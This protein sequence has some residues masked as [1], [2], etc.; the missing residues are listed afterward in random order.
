MVWWIKAKPSEA[1]ARG[2]LE[3]VR[4]RRITVV[5]VQNN[6][7]QVDRQDDPNK[8][9]TL[10]HLI[11]LFRCSHC[12]GKEMNG[13]IQ[14][15]TECI[16]FNEND[17]VDMC[18]Y[19]VQPTFFEAI[20]RIYF[21][22]LIIESAQST[23]PN[24][25]IKAINQLAYRSKQKLIVKWTDGR[26]DECN[27]GCAQAR[28]RVKD[29][30]HKALDA[31][32][33]S[34]ELI[35]LLKTMSLTSIKAIHIFS[36]WL[37]L[38]HYLLELKLKLFGIEMCEIIFDRLQLL[39]M[40][41]YE[42]QLQQFIIDLFNIWPTIQDDKLNKFV[43][44]HFV[45]FIQRIIDCKTDESNILIEQ[46]T[47][48]ICANTPVSNVRGHMCF[49]FLLKELL[50][51]YCEARL[52]KAIKKIDKGVILYFIDY[53]IEN[54]QNDTNDHCSILL[55]ILDHISTF[56]EIDLLRPL[57]TYTIK[58]PLNL[59]CFELIKHSLCPITTLVTYVQQATHEQVSEL[60]ECSE[61]D[62]A[63]QFIPTLLTIIEALAK[64]SQTEK[65]IFDSRLYLIIQK[66]LLIINVPSIIIRLIELLLDIGYSKYNKYNTD[67]ANFFLNQ[68]LA[69]FLSINFENP[70][71]LS[72][73]VLFLASFADIDPS[74]TIRCE[75]LFKAFFRQIEESTNN[76]SMDSC[77]FHLLS[78]SNEIVKERSRSKLVEL[79]S[80][81]TLD[82]I[83]ILGHTGELKRAA[84]ILLAE[85]L[86]LSPNERSVLDELIENQSNDDQSND[87]LIG[88]QRQQASF[89]STELTST[90]EIVRIGHDDFNHGH[91]LLT[92][93]KSAESHKIDHILRSYIPHLHFDQSSPIIDHKQQKDRLILTATARENV[94]K[95]LEVLDD[96]VPILLEGSTGVGKSA[97]VMEAAKLSGRELKR[98]NMSSRIS[99]DDLLGKVTIVPGEQGQ[100]V[101]FK[102]DNGPFT[103]AFIEGYWMLFDELNL[104]QDTVLQAIESA[105]DR[106]QLTIRNGSSAQQSVVV[107]HMH[108]NFR[109][110]A[111]QN[112]NTGFFKNKREK[113]SPSF[114]SRFRPLIF[115]ELPDIEWREIAHRKLLPYLFDEA[116]SLAELMVS[117]FNAKIKKMLNNEEQTLIE[118][119]PYAEIS[120]REL[121]KWIDLITWQAEN[122]LW[123]SDGIQRTA[124]LSF[125][126]WCVYGA[127]YR[128]VGR[129]L[130]EKILTDDGKGGWGSPALNDI[131]FTVDHKQNK[132]FFDNV[133]CSIR[134]DS[135]I[136][137]SEN[138]WNRII[139]SAEL[140]NV[141]YDKN[142]WNLAIQT[143]QAVHKLML[144][145][146]FIYTHAVYRIDR[147]WLEEWIISAAQSHRLEKHDEF[148]IHG[149]QLYENHVRHTEAQTKIRSCFTNI[150]KKVDFTKITFKD[151]LV[152]PEI[153]YVL[154]NRAL[155]TLK[156]V[157]FNRTIKQPILVTGPEGCGKSELLL[158]L[159]WF[160]GQQVQQLN[161]T[162][163]TEPSA[164]IGQLIPNDNSDKNEQNKD[165][166]LIWQ[167]GSVTTAYTTGQWVLLD[168]LSV[169]ESS[170]LERLNP[171][172]EQNPM[173]CLTEK[174]ET[175]K[176]KMHSDYQM[177]ATMTPPDGRQQSHGNVSG[178]SSELSPALYNRFG[179]VHMM[180]ISFSTTDNSSEILQIAKAL[181]SDEP[182]TDHELAVKFC[183]KILEFYKSNNRSFPKFT[184]RNIIRLLDSAYLLRLKFKSEL[185]FISSLW[186]AYHVTIANQIKNDDLKNEVTKHVKELLL[187]SKKST[188]LKQPNFIDQIN[189]N[190]EHI[191]TNSRLNYANAV[192]GAV[193]CKIPLLLEGPAAVGKTALIS[194]LWKHMK[195][196]NNNMTSNLS[197]VKLARV[198]NTDTT[199]IQD[200]L[201][202]F[203]PVNKDFVFQEGA[204]YRAMK[205][206]WWFLADEFNL[207]DPS[208]MN[209]LFPL[210][211][212]KNSIAI[213]SSGKVIKARPGFHFFATQND[214]SYA[215]R[216]QLPV[217]LRNRF[218]EV[219]FDD[220]PANELP[221]IIYERN[222]PGKEKPKC[223]KEES[224]EKLSD[225]YHKV[226]KKQSRITFRE[227]VKWLHRHA[228]FSP[229]KELWPVVG[230]SLLAVKYP[231]ESSMNESLMQDL[232]KVWPNIKLL[233]TPPIEIRSVGTSVRFREDDLY[234]DVSNMKLSDSVVSTSPESFRRS[235]VRLA[236]A[237][238]AKEPVL[239]V[240]PTSCK[241]LLVETWARLSDRANEL[242]KVHLTPDT[243]AGNLIGELQPYSFLDL[244]KRLP[245]MAERVYIRFRSLYRHE[246][247]TLTLAQQDDISLQ[248]LTDAIRIHL[249][250]AIAAFE[251]AY[252]LSEQHRQQK[253]EVVDDYDE[254]IAQ[255][256]ER[257]TSLPEEPI[258]NTLINSRSSLFRS[259]SERNSNIP[260]FKQ[261]VYDDDDD[262]TD[263]ALLDMGRTNKNLSYGRINNGISSAAGLDDGF[264]GFSISTGLNDGFGGFSTSTGLNDGF[265]DFSTSTGLDDGFDG[266]NTADS[267]NDGFSGFSNST[268]QSIVQR[269]KN[270]V[271]IETLN[272]GFGGYTANIDESSVSTSTNQI[273]TNTLDDGFGTS[274]ASSKTTVQSQS[275]NQLNDGFDLLQYVTPS[276]EI[277]EPNINTSNEQ[278][279]AL[280]ND[281]FS[282][283]VTTNES[284][285]NNSSSPQ[286][287]LPM[288]STN[289][290]DYPEELL[291]AISDIIENFKSMF[292]QTTYASFISK[293]ATLRDYHDKFLKAWDCLKSPQFDRSKPIFLFNDGPVTTSAKQ[294]AILFLEDL[295]LP[296]QA[297]I[298]RLNSMLEPS[299]TFALTEDITSQV[300]KGQLDINLPNYFQIFATVHQEQSHQLLKL[301][302]ATR[303]RFTEIHIP[304]YSDDDLKIIVK[305]E[306]NKI[307]IDK[308]ELDSFVNTMFLLRNKLIRDTEWKLK[309][310]IQL[311][312]RWTDF[313]KNH[314]QELLLTHRMLLGARF[315][316][317][318]QL[319][320]LRHAALFEDWHK[321]LSS[322]IEYKD[323]EHI[324]K[325]PDHTHGA[326]TL[327]LIASEKSSPKLPFEVGHDYV[328][329][330]YT[331][332]RYSF[333]PK[334]DTI[335][336]ET[337]KKELTCVP[338]PTLLNQIARIFAASS[339][340]TPLLLEGPPGIGK[341]QVVTQV[342]SLLNKEC[343][344]I[345]LSANTSLDQLIGCIIP[346]FING[347][348]T[349]QWQEGRV[350]S[351][352]KAQKWILFDE[353]NL[354]APE[355]LEG[356]T[357]LFYRGVTEFL[358]P[359]T[360]EKVPLKNV[361]LFATMN[362]STI[363]GG[364]SKLPRSIS[365]LFTIVQLDDYSE[366]ELRIILNQIF[367]KELND[368]KTITMSQIESLFDMHTSLKLLV[369]E[370]TLGR[371]GGPYELNL[372]DLSKFRDVFRGSIKSQLFHYQYINTT[373]DEDKETKSDD[374]TKQNELNSTMNTSD[375]SFLSIRKFAQV[376]YACQFQDQKDFTKA[377]EMINA[378]FPINETLSKRENDCS[379]DMAVA[380]VVR[381]G[382]IYINTG[383]EDISSSN[384]GL[385]HTKKTVRQLELLAAACQSKRAI[386]LEGDICSRKSSLVI[387]LARITRNRLII[388]PLHENFETTD[389]IGSWLP[390][391]DNQS[392]ES[393]VFEKIDKMFKQII[394][395]LFL[396]VMPLLFS[397]SNKYVFDKCRTILQIRNK[398]SFIKR[399]E[400]IKEEIQALNDT[401]ILIN[402]ICKIPQM[403]NEIKLRLSCYSRQAENFVTKLNIIRV[404][405][406]QEM[407]FT[408]VE[409]EF[410]QAIR[411][412]WWVL[413]D[414]VNSAPSDVL[415]RLNSLT[416]DN[417]M[418]SLYE[419][420]KG[421][422]LKENKGIHPNF[423]LFTTANLNRI[424]S[425]KLSSAFLNRVIRI[426]LPQIDD[427]DIKTNNDPTTSDLYE[428]LSTQL[429]TIPAGKQLAHLLIL[430]HLNV[431][432]DV[433]DSILTYTSDFSVTYR[434]LEQC[435][436][437]IFYLISRKVKP[438]DACY[439][440][441]IRC[442]CSS[443]QN[444]EQYKSF[445]TKLQQTID[446]LNLRSSST[447]YS[448][449]S[450][451]L[452]HKQAL[453]IQE[454][455][456]IRSKFIS[457]ER[458]LIELIFNMI[459][460]LTFDNKSIKLTCDLLI[461]FID[462]I[463][464]IMTPSDP[465]LI[466]LKQ[467]LIN[468]DNLQTNLEKDLSDLMQIKNISIRIGLTRSTNIGKLIQGLISNGS[469]WLCSTCEEISTLLELFIRN[470]SFND[471]YERLQF[472][473]RTIS[474]ID[475]FHQFFSSSIFGLFDRKI[476]LTR[477][478]S[479]VIQYLRP[480]LTY[481]DKCSVY[482]LFHDSAFIDAKYLF[483]KNLLEHFD[484][485]LVWSFER[486]QSFP[487]RSTRK[488]LRKLIEH[489]INTTTHTD[490]MASIQYFATLL[491][492]I[493][494][495][496]T[497][498]DYLTISVRNALQK[499]VCITRD[500]IFESELKFSSLKL[501]NKMTKIIGTLVR[502]L[503]SESSSL[504]TYY[505]RIKKDLELKRTTLERCNENIQELESQISESELVNQN[506][507]K[508]SNKGT[509]NLRS[510]L[511]RD[512]SV[513]HP[514]ENP[515]N[516]RLNLLKQEE[517]KLKTEVDILNEEYNR[518][519]R[520]RITILDKA[521]AG[522]EK[523]YDEIRDLLQSDDYKFVRERLEQPDAKQLNYLLQLLS[524]ARKN[525]T[526]INREG[527]LDTRA[528]L[529]TS[530][531]RELIEHDDILESSLAFFLCGYYFL[532]YFDQR[533]R[534]Y[535][536]SNWQ[537][538]NDDININT[539]NPHDLIIYCPNKNPYESCLLSITKQNNSISIIIWCVQD[540]YI[541]DLHTILNETLPDGIQCH[542]KQKEFQHIKT[543]ITENGQELFGLACLMH[544]Y[545][546][547]DITSTRIREI[548]DQI[549]IIFDEL[550]YFVE[551]NAIE[552]KPLTAFIYQNINRFQSELDSLNLS[553]NS[554]DLWI[555][556]IQQIWT[557]IKPYQ[558]K[559]S[560]TVA[561]KLQEEL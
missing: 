396:F 246:K 232:G 529:A 73:I 403:P 265:G 325:V 544:L 415:E 228:I 121:L 220:F 42:K 490:M 411:E 209:T 97:T 492:W 78:L 368:D 383:S 527:L 477:L 25:C 213:P 551:H 181:L 198:N 534:F 400:T 273:T 139:N 36:V 104:A 96:P 40:I 215:N 192:L 474:I 316:Y 330:H 347:I 343:E 421:E 543:T 299:P 16:S 296:S 165:K 528:I 119:G 230:A 109:L 408:F 390:T 371:T 332:V 365:N 437:T 434:L 224:T 123:P 292:G 517:T 46:L 476:E 388:I 320:M 514:D 172:L 253:D 512:I 270:K 423:R 384:I 420:S 449:A 353:L 452:D 413:L 158:T 425:N 310:D 190:K 333:D 491:E 435:V 401:I 280:L 178:A 560:S 9:L 218:L 29:L 171:V 8:P 169:A 150:F 436:H 118:M 540:I 308:K 23:D 132:I 558:E 351:A 266:L 247:K 515:L 91:K 323:Y 303:S 196:P 428:L 329:L 107:Y 80:P 170:V 455:Q 24:V 532:P 260:S 100:S 223:L 126:A 115:K 236:L 326:L 389:L 472:L 327:E 173:L 167:N 49:Y 201:G 63:K 35:S 45:Q 538:L 542:I 186:T 336:I 180:D 393:P 350:L 555:T 177:V 446:K 307:N 105:L 207:A 1:P 28:L 20:W 453:W 431:K 475:V 82:I 6:R 239:L 131:K 147:S 341:T 556:S 67:I 519:D 414:N 459:K 255:A 222:E 304:S 225:F 211:E 340:K 391:G 248:P 328:S 275:I 545:Q 77:K 163:E 314:H 463:L 386:L 258:Q 263:I 419:N 138:E 553:N 57:I 244:L 234:I 430:T 501:S 344:R 345:N 83:P 133:Q 92:D 72:R 364:R 286:S 358:V 154:T 168:N 442:Y 243:E 62:I 79:L 372:R 226:I 457:F 262:N 93:L 75:P 108:E 284:I 381:I 176:Q 287:S 27:D 462:N 441:L 26:E 483:R 135:S 526:L 422:I 424:Y 206:G 319:P 352:I 456:R 406:Q 505:S 493:S 361:L 300:D 217:S 195:S 522:R 61:T 468:N 524:E 359:N 238:H 271:T 467:I 18:R 256:K 504:N 502:N 335:N 7:L 507:V 210:L 32:Q 458:Y 242:I 54:N 184:L 465:K 76:E 508:I 334:Y 157:C 33:D 387:E 212:G 127:R 59:I 355:V 498:D 318:D 520:S 346:R 55:S 369:R 264:G 64:N 204:L 37:E 129:T 191:L 183:H 69:K 162:P 84:I 409:S 518:Y 251:K 70:S 113:L 38:F 450:D 480:L 373:D 322:T 362:P 50:P 160:C 444:H 31:C 285:E 193:A 43:L 473:Q 338:T 294:G 185:N 279:N 274:V 137:D 412:G 179:I 143:H 231:S 120:I 233:K 357:P 451:E 257:Q 530:F 182:D 533:Y 86:E 298:E 410:V 130:V 385:I 14:L 484:S 41:G 19:L 254:I 283:V 88:D 112:P 269:A 159:A 392:H 52:I 464:L 245:A 432:Q 259:S 114:L 65:Y 140:K 200:Y 187:T 363:G 252:S 375:A 380:T 445:I 348:R 469:L 397:D 10:V 56:T 331:D 324:F 237:V 134:L 306:L 470:T 164:L 60:L 235:L 34:E 39:D 174:G 509:S 339:S 488:D 461:L 85:I 418:L 312:F 499:N 153:P 317:F 146:E 404:T 151:C 144:D 523:L 58:Y 548:Y 106:R 405:E 321:N 305:A 511:S 399:I 439:W 417:P 290:I 161:I 447:V 379:I 486:A 5:T 494:L 90:S 2:L 554:D 521:I 282:D 156:Q 377:C 398:N 214:A 281:G 559:F 203:L 374:I 136:D 205:N 378:K 500:F 546:S 216:H 416:E 497:F 241:T 13:L 148:A 549:K 342:C 547:D 152:Q 155:K 295:D 111:T 81:F 349:F 267:L 525:S 427:Y 289:K 11:R 116:E 66:W 311:L 53:V 98:Y 337:L 30:V 485:G 313:I 315:F 21:D 102:F 489:M 95:V 426:C 354:A 189:P 496:W 249:P 301:S 268:D 552:R 250:K 101:Q 443:L 208:V 503:P 541:S 536:I 145:R 478:C 535:I 197:S 429:I 278:D 471:T 142:L 3:H 367:K 227:L 513:F 293:D 4:E 466:Q 149:C 71:R 276:K 370:G 482:E 229:D 240:G 87:V 382:S 537:Q 125:S 395:D 89:F 48:H 202:T 175:N 51:K 188:E 117:N 356:L 557:F 166:K 22:P 221:K 506:E 394:K 302:P 531:G 402:D 272:D 366:E 124:L 219:Q 309:N 407:G 438:V 68:Y 122:N 561:Q 360:G 99:I 44:N 94:T 481:K 550:K 495:Q 261:K 47:E 15:L 103:M 110:F 460:I 74:T 516:N 141:K 539:L 454:S 128:H 487:I 288:T 433:K 194:H 17:A 12:T 510:R 479:S 448:T 277:K 440:S 376:V 199:T 291:T 297:V